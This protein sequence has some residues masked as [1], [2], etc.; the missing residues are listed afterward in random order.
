MTDHGIDWD[1]AFT[2]MD[3][4]PDGPAFPPRWMALAKEF[5]ESH[6]RSDLDLAYG[7]SK[8]EVFDLFYPSD[9]PN[10]LVVFVHGG[11]WMKFDKAVWSHLAAGPLA[12]GWAVAMPSYTLAPEAR[13]A[14]ITQQIAAA[15]QKAATMVG[16]PIRL[17]GHSAGGHLVSRMLCKDIDLGVAT[18]RIAHVVSISGVHD[19]TALQL[20][21]LNDDLKITPKE[22]ASESP[23]KL[24]PRK[25]VPVTCW[26]GG[27]E[28]PE[29]MR[30]NQLLAETWS[31]AGVAVTNVADPRKHHF[32]VID[33]LADPASVLCDALL[34]D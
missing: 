23:A 25:D 34:G 2:N 12:R 5:R 4:I 29:F 20:T 11:Y 19:L 26:V 27:D 16:G 18:D 21:K 17:A 14:Q 24:T 6:A 3:F 28:R 31:R 13:I 1:E 10:G 33:G 32:D 7:S 15:V 22:A 30:Q 9:T 8:R